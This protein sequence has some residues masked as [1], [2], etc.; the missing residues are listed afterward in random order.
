MGLIKEKNPA[1]FHNMMSDIYEQARCIVLFS[2]LYARDEHC[3]MFLV[4][5]HRLVAQASR[6]CLLRNS[7]SMT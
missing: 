3:N 2:V 6:V 7:T 1:A 5:N 4:S